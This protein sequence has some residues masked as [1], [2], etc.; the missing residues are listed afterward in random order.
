MDTNPICLCTSKKEK[1]KTETLRECHVK[2]GIL[3]Q[4]QEYQ[5]LPTNDQELGDRHKKVPLS[6]FLEGNNLSLQSC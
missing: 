2:I 3:S 5:G 1:L 6:L 4:A